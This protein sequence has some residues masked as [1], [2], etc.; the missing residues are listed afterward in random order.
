MA[1]TTWDHP[2]DYEG[3]RRWI[4]PGTP[5]PEARWGGWS[6]KRVAGVDT[7]GSRSGSA[8]ARRDGEFDGGH[9]AHGAVATAVGPTGGMACG[10]RPRSGWTRSPARTRDGWEPPTLRTVGD[11]AASGTARSSGRAWRAVAP[12]PRPPRGRR[13]AAVRI[14]SRPATGWLRGRTPPPRTRTSGV[15]GE[16][17]P[18]SLLSGADT[19][20]GDGGASQ[21][22][23]CARDHVMARH[24]V[25]ARLRADYGPT[26]R[27]PGRLPGGRRRARTDPRFECT[28]VGCGEPA[29]A[30]N[31]RPAVRRPRAS[32]TSNRRGS[33][34]QRAAQGRRNDL[35]RPKGGASKGGSPSVERKS[36]FVPTTDRLHPSYLGRPAP[37]R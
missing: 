5:S 12:A 30:G 21:A 35:R 27:N 19:C 9:A 29:L 6:P 18:S 17:A 32:A 28:A 13:G 4:T 8:A 7:A 33:R 1:P 2:P 25:P 11:A 14:R 34:Q 37:I 24:P 23:R 26:T 15:G 16:T 22:N 31:S 3:V 20:V 10:A 36:S